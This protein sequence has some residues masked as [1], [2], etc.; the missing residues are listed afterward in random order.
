METFRVDFS[1]WLRSH[2]RGFIGGSLMI[3]LVRSEA[4]ILPNDRPLAGKRIGRLVF[5]GRLRIGF[6][7]NL[8]WPF[9]FLARGLLAF[10]PPSLRCRP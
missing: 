9:S 4:I 7:P 2:A 5:L 10:A 8:G 1:R 3:Y 6:L